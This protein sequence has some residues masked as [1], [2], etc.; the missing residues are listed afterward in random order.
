MGYMIGKD[1]M[2]KCVLLDASI[3]IEAH[4][5]GVWENLIERV[6]II[7]FSIV[8]HQ[9][10]LFY[11][12]KEKGIPGPINLKRLIDNGKIQ[13]ISATP[14]EIALFLIGLTGFLSLDS[15]MERLSLYH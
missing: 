5:I 14:E 11:S 3:V 8:A 15:M 10:A 9:E 6:E 2:L 7:V 13:E 4:K 12:E 1:M